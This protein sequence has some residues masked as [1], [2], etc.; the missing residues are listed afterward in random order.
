ML[1][2]WWDQN[3]IV[4]YELLQPGTTINDQLYKE[5]L[6]QL[7]LELQHKRPEYAKRNE[8]VI[9]QHDNARLHVA[10]LVK[11]TLETLG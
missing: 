6:T 3:G 8:K 7:S 2:I 10:K 11:E 9:L 1:C 4:Y 5:Q